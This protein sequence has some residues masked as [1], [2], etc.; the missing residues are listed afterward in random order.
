[1]IKKIKKIFSFPSIV[2]QKLILIQEAL[3]RIESRQILTQSKENISNFEFRVFS[4]WGE[5]GIIQFLINNIKIKHKKFVE[6][7]V[8]D[9]LQ[10]NTR[11]LVS[12]DNWSGLIIDGSKK[13]VEYI[14]NDYIYWAHELTAV[15]KFITKDNINEIISEN[16]ISGE[17]GILSVDIDGNDY[18]VWDSI[19][20]ISPAIV[21]CEYNSIFGKKAEVTTPY[22]SDF[23]RDKYHFSNTVYGAS[24]NAL[25][26]LAKR[27]GYSLVA[28]NTS[29]NNIF[30]VRDDLL[31]SEVKKVSVSEVYQKSKFREYFSDSKHLTFD[32][33]EQRRKNIENIK[34]FNLTTNKLEKLKNIDTI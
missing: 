23:I 10:S 1:M 20:C 17:I 5:D 4:Q 31:T 33:F 7:G 27:K 19:N 24:I 32:N 14:K 22:I 3:G 11:F 26:S 6:F 9:Y 18:W 28:G 12:N 25:T 8:E 15:C 16:N 29:G 21:I 13:N 30:F 2:L 34:V